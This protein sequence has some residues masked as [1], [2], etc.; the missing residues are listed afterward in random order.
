MPLLSPGAVVRGRYRI[1]RPLGRGGMGA[2]FL[3]RD[4]L[5][6]CDIA[7]KVLRIGSTEALE[8][9]RNEIMLLQGLSQPRLTQ[10]HDFGAARETNGAPLYFYTATLV[11]GVSLE[12]HVVG[13]RWSEVRTA[14]ADAVDALRFLHALGVRHGDFKPA[15][16]LV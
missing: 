3:G 13:R 8:A 5:V 10:V 14:L 1:G 16:I 11:E 2:T 12:E 4:L 6:E 9:F 7:I 15:N